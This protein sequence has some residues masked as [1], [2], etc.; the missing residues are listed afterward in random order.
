M[1]GSGGPGDPTVKA[2]ID[3]EEYSRKCA[4]VE[5]AAKAADPELYE[6]IIYAVTNENISF[7]SLKM[8]MNMPCERDRYYNSRR[9]FYFILDSLM[10]KEGCN[11]EN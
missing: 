5:A 4:F 10:Q 11:D 7:N 6:Y 8:Q 9:K 3:C 2:A 1:P